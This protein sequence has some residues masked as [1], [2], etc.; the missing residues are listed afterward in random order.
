MTTCPKGLLEKAL[1]GVHISLLAEHGVNQIAILI[2][3]TIQVAPLS[4]DS[5]IS[6]INVPG[7]PC[8]SAT[9]H[10]QLISYQG[11]K[12]GFPVAQRLMRK[13]KTAFQEDLGKIT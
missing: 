4:L 10:P 8:L 3:G 9:P 7:G 11:S 1:S 2:N 5:S 13:H 12:S 6:L